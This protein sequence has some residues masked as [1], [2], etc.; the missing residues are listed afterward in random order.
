[1]LLCSIDSTTRRAQRAALCVVAGLVAATLPSQLPALD[2][3]DLSVRDIRG[4]DWSASGISVRME[5]ASSGHAT[6]RIKIARVH[7]AEP[8]GELRNI[9]ISCPDPIVHDF[10][11]GC[12]AARVSATHSTF[13]QLTFQTAATFDRQRQSLAV[14][15]HELHIA[16]GN[17]H[18]SANWREQGWRLV[19][20]ADRLGISR[21]RKFAAPWVSLPADIEINGT[22]SPRVT[23]VGRGAVERIALSVNIE[24][25]T[26]NNSD[27]TLATDKLAMSIN[28][29]LKPTE[30]GFAV[31]SH[32]AFSGGQ[33]YRDPVFVDLGHVPLALD[34]TGEWNS[35][36]KRLMVSRFAADQPGV[37]RAS[38][39]AELT[40]FGATTISA[41][42]FK[43]EQGLFPGLYTTYLQPFLV[44]TDLKDLAAR[45]SVQGTVEIRDGSP[46]ALEAELESI[47]FDDTGGHMAL[48]GL[49][50]RVL[51]RSDAQSLAASQISWHDGQAYGFAGGAAAINF[52]AGG[53][54]FR[55]LKPT[56]LPVFD[57][58]L[59]IAEFELRDLGL[60]SMTVLFDASIEPISMR[61]ICQVL[62]WPEFSGTI[63]GRI[64]RLTFKDKVLSF[65]GDLE[66]RVFDGRMVVSKL[67]LE[68]PLGVWPRL[69]GDVDVDNLDLESVTGTFS[70]GEIT[71]R[72]S[73]Y[74]HG[75]ELFAWQ[76]V[77]FDA[78][79]ETPPGD[80]S[81]H[82]ISQRA[83]SNISAIGG[84]SGGNAMAALSGGLLRFFENFK[85]ARLGLACKLQDEVCLMHG[86]GP[87]R[88]GFYIV[89]GRGLPRIDVIGSAGRIYWPQLVANLKAATK[90]G[91]AKVKTGRE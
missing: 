32:L 24:A 61:R 81:E 43:L 62:G 10:V 15:A 49:A 13:G 8:L 47:D 54:G 83:I 71:G 6:A 77:A 75:I 11:V 27:G 87:A 7:F 89:R 34:L 65:D 28:A 39:I 4:A 80:R 86:I 45:G 53:R 17:W 63:S 64:P 22:L 40:P 44:N 33:A 35:T 14:Q 38:G 37:L 70:F 52:V 19:A 57:G 51:W 79:L 1:M 67:R 82:R 74:I 60:P 55:M 50:G 56:R 78:V 9:D 69:F 3:I 36:D 85:Y 73:G 30:Q 58:G 26:L 23:I 21:L 41:L 20:G 84:G 48:H 42:T 25:L 18:V 12:G 29:N 90:T 76:P 68:D 88:N 2:S 46:V 66:A 91:D 31:E 16:G 5:L 72:L 59:A